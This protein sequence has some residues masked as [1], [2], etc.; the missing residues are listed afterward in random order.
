MIL[1]LRSFKACVL[2]SP[3]FPSSPSRTFPSGGGAGEGDL[4]RRLPDVNVNG[5]LLHEDVVAESALL[6]ST[7]TQAQS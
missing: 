7:T 5:A 2:S 6:L 4:R 1:I 3:S